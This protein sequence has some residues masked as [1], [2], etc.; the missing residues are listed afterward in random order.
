MADFSLGFTPPR[1]RASSLSSRMLHEAAP[2][3]PSS[4]SSMMSWWVF[5]RKWKI[6]LVITLLNICGAFLLI[7]LICKI[8]GYNLLSETYDDGISIVIIHI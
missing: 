8:H 4:N 6:V 2:A 7:F 5:T 3:K 1:M